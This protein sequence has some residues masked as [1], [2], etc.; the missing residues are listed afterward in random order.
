MAVVAVLPS[1]LYIPNLLSSSC[2][3][4]DLDNYAHALRNPKHL[5]QNRY[6]LFPVDH[7]YVLPINL[8]VRTSGLGL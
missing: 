6:A 2:A 8:G 1:W 4:V 7:E 5:A 3:A